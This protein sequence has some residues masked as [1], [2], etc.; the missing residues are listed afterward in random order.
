MCLEVHP[1]KHKKW[2]ECLPYST[3]RTRQ[4]DILTTFPRSNTADLLSTT[5]CNN[6]LWAV[7]S[8]HPCFVHIK[9]ISGSVCMARQHCTEIMKEILHIMFIETG[10]SAQRCSL[11]FTYR[12]LLMAIQKSVKPI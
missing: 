6:V 1:W 3:N 9:Y 4:G 7:N 8:G 2:R 11:R 10:R 5:L 12:Q